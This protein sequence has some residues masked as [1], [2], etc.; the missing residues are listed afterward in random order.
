MILLPVPVSHF[1]HLEILYFPSDE[2]SMTFQAY[3]LCICV[4]KTKGMV[5]LC[6][7][8]FRGRMLEVLYVTAWGIKREIRQ[9]NNNIGNDIGTVFPKIIL[10]GQ[11]N[12]QWIL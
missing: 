6:R 8:I 10:K 3:H 4:T 11:A 7:N 5:I 1:P 9:Q 12:T 2:I